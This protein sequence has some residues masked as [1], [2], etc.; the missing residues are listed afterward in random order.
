M[1]DFRAGGGRRGGIP[2]RKLLV[3]RLSS[4]GDIIHTL[5]AA[6]LLREAF[7]EATLGWMVEE[8]WTALLS[9][10]DSM[11]STALGP[12]K[13]LVNILHPVA[14]AAWRRAPLSDETWREA[15]AALRGLREVGYELAVDF[16]GAVRT[17][18]IA[19]WAGVSRMAGFQRPR[20][21]IASM[22]YARREAAMGTHIVEQNVS[23]AAAVAGVAARVPDFR[24]PVDAQSE[25][26]CDTA[27]RSRGVSKFAIL[28]PGAGWGAKQ[29][30]TSRYGELAGGLA[31]MGLRSLVNF[32]PGEERL[33]KEVE[34]ASGGAAE[35]V[36]CSLSELIALT[37]R[38]SLLVGGDTGPMHLAIAL[39]VPAV[40]IFGP[41]NPARNGPY[42]EHSVA[43][44]SPGSPTTHARRDRPDPGI[45]TIST[46]D[47]LHA[48]GRLLEKTGG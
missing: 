22:F 40:A 15:R 6:T 3:V 46:M 43:L 12:G 11:C 31:A 29:W 27:L 47:V 9:A 48:A 20:E 8:R 18:L 35:A 32:G 21:P 19:R 2:L 30:P 25:Q 28:N 1:I 23:L 16:Q 24:L 36:P 45:L 41:T 7:P 26:W 37:R 33:A 10:R 42:G 13:P 34:L 17:A 14:M 44:R 39:K 5:P 38:S 4:M